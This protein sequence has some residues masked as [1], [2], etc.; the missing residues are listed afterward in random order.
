MFFKLPDEMNRIFST[1]LQTPDPSSIALVDDAQKVLISSDESRLTTNE[2]VP[3]FTTSLDKQKAL[4]HT[5]NT[6]GYQGYMG[7]NWLGVISQ[8][9]QYA[10]RAIDISKKDTEE[11]Q[12][13]QQSN[14]V[15]NDLKSINL[16]AI[17]LNS[18]LRVLTLNGKSVSHRLKAHSFMP[19]L[20]KL[21]ELGDEMGKIVSK[22]VTEINQT[23]LANLKAN[24]VFYSN[25]AVDI[26]DRNLYERA[27]DCRWWALT[28]TFTNLL[29][30]AQLTDQDKSELCD[31]LTYINDLY[32][33]Y[34]NVFLFD[35]KGNIISASHLDDIPASALNVAKY[36]WFEKTNS[37]TNSQ[38]YSV[39]D[40]EPSPLYDDQET[41]IYSAAIKSDRGH[42]IGGIGVVFDS[43]PEFKAM[44]EDCLPVSETGEPLEHASALF[45]DRQANI[46][47]STHEQWP[48]GDKL[49]LPE[50]LIK[51]KK[52]ESQHAMT[53]LNS[54]NYL[55]GVTCSSGY[56]EYKTTGDYNNDVIAVVM[57]QM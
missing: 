2:T 14:L 42:T 1:L 49:L 35:S 43:K 44:L 53:E 32:T 12:L 23:A 51:I 22:V 27:N 18:E 31:A 40:F 36:P 46:I 8:P 50:H 6:K 15:S 28:P 19:I 10:F 5:S 21:Q 45:I 17:K 33:V 24:C 54:D 4:I 16:E 38:Q 47:A 11:Y 29:A 7:L 57:I 30:K 13:W 37:L 56:R 41:Y 26:M 25:L 48:V 3:A 52:G 34:T 9:A 39:S 20:E 55:V